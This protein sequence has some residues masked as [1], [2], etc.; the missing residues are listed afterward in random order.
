M[1]KIVLKGRFTVLCIVCVLFF[2]IL[3]CEKQKEENKIIRGKWQLTTIYPPKVEGIAYMLGDFTP[4][5]II[6]EFKANNVLAV[7]GNIDNN[8]ACL[9]KGKHSYEVTLTDIS[10]G[11]LSTNLT[12]LAQHVVEIDN[13]SYCFSIVDESNNP[14]LYMTYWDE[15]NNIY[16]FVKK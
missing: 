2:T 6:Y 13:I 7:S 10:N 16:T 8:Y 12:N 5:N 1:K 4:M 11:S 15:N 14:T 9:K 3:G